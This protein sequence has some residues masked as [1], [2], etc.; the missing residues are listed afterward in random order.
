MPAY[1]WIFLILNCSLLLLFDA[2]LMGWPW[3][4]ILKVN[5]LRESANC[6]SATTLRIL[7]EGTA[8]SRWDLTN[9]YRNWPLW[10]CYAS[11]STV[12][13]FQ[14]T[15]S[16]VGFGH[17]ST[18]PTPSPRYRLRHLN[19]HYATSPLPVASASWAHSHSSQRQL[20]PQL[21]LNSQ[22]V[23]FRSP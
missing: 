8:Q 4:S 22:P 14:W 1:W 7:P 9:E 13:C 3:I 20:L 10:L 19:R 6:N 16:S 11:H 18:G 23:R 15:S 21:H 17:W 12:L 5:E 2:W